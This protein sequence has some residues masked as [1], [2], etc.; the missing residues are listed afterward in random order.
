[1]LPYAAY[2]VTLYYNLYF[3]CNDKDIKEKAQ[4]VGVY[5]NSDGFLVSR[6]WQIQGA[7]FQN[8]GDA[9]LALFEMAMEEGWMKLMF[10]GIKSN[11]LDI[12]PSWPPSSWYN[13]FY[14]LL[15]MMLGFVLLR[16]LFVGVI[17]QAFM[18]RNGTALLTV[19]F[20]LKL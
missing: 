5:V 4:C 8:I 18:T 13:V 6:L 12:Q 7:S 3:F 15:W 10:K 1:M 19:F 9:L 11:G 17:L 2:G 16:N 20:L 14:F